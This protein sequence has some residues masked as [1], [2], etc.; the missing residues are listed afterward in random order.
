MR[1]Y[2]QFADLVADAGV[3]SVFGVLGDGNMQWIAAYRELAGCSWRPAWHEAGAVWMAD[4]WAGITGDVGVATVTM[5][6]G[7]AQALPALFTAVRARRPVVVVTAALPDTQPPHAQ[8]SAQRELVEAAGARYVHIR[9]AGGFS[10]GLSTALESARSGVPCV[11]AVDLNV[12]ESADGAEQEPSAHA[13]GG[14]AGPD[15]EDA[16][17]DATGLEAAVALLDAARAPLVVLGAGVRSSGSVDAAIELADRLGALVGATIGGHGALPGEPWN[18]GVLGM[19]ANPTARSLAAEAD[20]VVVLGADL[21]RYNS[22]GGALGHDAQ[23][24]RVDCRPPSATWSPAA[25]TLHLT[26]GVATVLDAL[27]R[28]LPAEVRTGLRTGEVRDLLHR[29][30]A[31]QSALQDLE[32]RD[33]PN[34]WAVVAELDRRL[35]GNAHVVVGIGH[36]WYFV[37]PYLHPEPARSLHFARGF[38]SIGQA[39]PVG[40]GAALASAG[41]PVVVVE[42]DGSAIMNVQELQ[43]AVRLGADLLVVVLDNHAY[44]S[45]L[46]KLALAGL[47]TAT[48][49]FD[50]TPFDIAAVARAMGATARTAADVSELGAA[51]DELSTVA[52]VRVIAARISATTMSEVY[53]RQHGPASHAPPPATGLSHSAAST[54]HPLS[55]DPSR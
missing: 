10:A 1:A 41:R 13:A 48:S 34:P 17:L 19:M 18:L 37:A 39:I 9:S 24:V 27:L 6:P 5:G 32:T 35:P 42:G 31:R 38:A 45:E 15:V 52:G 8:F 30:R 28:R 47:D 33:G 3:R 55:H 25:R 23:I 21:D 46:H 51:L 29:E 4:G 54:V 7:L 40:I 14:P 11:L 12:F 26:G 49:T 50:D 36:F 16:A 20:V 2:E 44:G 22:D 53:V 43:A